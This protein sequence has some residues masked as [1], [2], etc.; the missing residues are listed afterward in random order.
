MTPVEALESMRKRGFDVEL[1]GGRLRVKGPPARNQARALRWLEAHWRDIRDLLTFEAHPVAAMIREVF[2]NAVLR[3]VHPARPHVCDGCDK[4]TPVLVDLAGSKLC[5]ICYQGDAGHQPLPGFAD[6][7]RDD[8]GKPLGPTGWHDRRG[9]HRGEAFIRYLQEIG[10]KLYRQEWPTGPDA[11]S[12]IA[13]K[14]K[15]TNYVIAAL[16]SYRDE[17]LPLAAPVKDPPRE[18]PGEAWVRV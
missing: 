18:G 13:P 6:V 5:R 17:L 9:R 15:L 10:A 8:E 7:P 2:P 3:E 14:D 12:C 16:R 1:V 4:K 11:L